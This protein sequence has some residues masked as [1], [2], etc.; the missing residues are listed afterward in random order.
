[1]LTRKDFAKVGVISA[2]AASVALLVFI[3]FIATFPS[4]ALFKIARHAPIFNSLQE[5]VFGGQ[6]DEVGSPAHNWLSDRIILTDRE[7][8]DA[9]TLKISGPSRNLRERDLFKA[10]FNKSDLRKVDFTGSNLDEAQFKGAKLQGAIFGCA[11]KR[12]PAGILPEKDGCAHAEG[13]IFDGALLEGSRF[14]YS[15]LQG[16]S[17]V[18]A[19]LIG[20]IL[21]RA[22][23][24]LR[25]LRVRSCR[26]QNW[27]MSA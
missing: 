10:V 26:A 24:E 3:I 2:A 19:D 13:A 12:Q 25:I 20:T 1:M 16:S 17:F 9:Y 4:E 6:P 27:F 8:V 14:E 22:E 11:P 7:L 15:D 18:G 23:L 21:L 5:L